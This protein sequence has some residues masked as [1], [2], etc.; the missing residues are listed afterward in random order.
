MQD[1][2]RALCAVADP[3]TAFRMAPRVAILEIQ[4]V[5]IVDGGAV[6]WSGAFAGPCRLKNDSRVVRCGGSFLRCRRIRRFL[7]GRADSSELLLA[8]DADARARAQSSMSGEVPSAARVP[9][10]PP[11]A[12]LRAC[13]AH[14]HDG[15]VRPRLARAD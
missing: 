10:H 13:G 6:A 12:A 3:V 9:R 14:A 2:K 8:A 5:F 4:S 15:Q 7:A 1:T 11:V